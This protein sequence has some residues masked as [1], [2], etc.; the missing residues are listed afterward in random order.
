M[1]R[2]HP[3]AIAIGVIIILLALGYGVRSA[4]E[5]HALNAAAMHQ[6][7]HASTERLRAESERIHAEANRLREGLRHSM[8]MRVL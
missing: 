2:N 3:D 7:L 8:H 4:R 6:Q 1:I 5:Q